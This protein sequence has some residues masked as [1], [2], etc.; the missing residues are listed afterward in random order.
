MNE[1]RMTK[2]KPVRRN[3]ARTRQ[4]LLET[5]IRLFSAK[6]F[7]GV[8]V[9]AIVEAA[10]VNKRMVYHYFGSKPGL[11]QEAL[12]EVYQR[13]EAVEFHAVNRGKTPREKLTRLLE[14]Y[15]EFLDNEP[16][17]T[18]FLQWENL[19][20]GVH[21]AKGRTLTK[22]PFL[23]Q[24]RAIVE[25]GIKLGQFHPN[26]N[27]PQLLIH[28]IGLCFIYHSNRFSLSAGLQIDLGDPKI[29]AEGLDQVIALVFDGIAT[30]E[31]PAS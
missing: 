19:E 9:D 21:I 2:P 27:V 3:A 10:K 14:T 24:F 8:S 25:D 5:A 6:G 4:K 18:R 11:Y 17:F 30:R 28:L 13:I 26:L 7:H 31:T 20:H 22:N 16:D 29:K 23:Q 1:P 12:H 15:F